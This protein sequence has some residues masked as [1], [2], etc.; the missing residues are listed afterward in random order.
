MLATLLLVPSALPAIQAPEVGIA[1]GRLAG[2]R[3]NGVA[4]FKGIPYAAPPVGPL[5]WRAPQSGPSWNGVRDAA[6]FGPVCPQHATEGLV[7][8]A[9]LPQSEDC[10][11]LNVWTPDLHPA[12]GLPVMVWIH[13]GGFDQGGSSVP[14]YDGGALA[15][16]GIVVV[17]FN[18]RLGRLGFFALPALAAEHPGEPFANYGLL[19]QIAALQWVR[20]NI[21]A[22]GGDPAEVTIF[23]ESAGGVSVDALMASPAARGL[24]ARAISESGAV[25]GTAELADAERSA[26][27][28]AQRLG[29]GGDDAL[30]KLRSASVDSILAAQ[31]DENGPVVDG[32]LLREDIA[33]A[34]AEGHIARVPYLT[35]TNS[36]EGSLLRGQT[37]DFL[38]AP[39]GDRLPSVRARYEE[40]GKI[41]DAEFDRLLFNDYFFAATS[42]LLAGFVAR[43]GGAAYVYRFQ[44][45]PAILRMRHAP[46]VMHGGEMAFVFGFG[47]LGAF[48][49]PQDLAVRDMVQAYWTNFAK[50]GDPNGAGLPEWPRFEG[51]APATLVIDDTTRAVPDFRKRETDVPL[52]M[53]AQRNRLPLP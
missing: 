37:A 25:F 52:E 9:D 29:A 31:G 23:G 17:T 1:A 42:R 43:A 24:F 12:A 33:V 32:T 4:V 45:L 8:R 48:A 26:A 20:D 2:A 38:T 3:A 44:F 51:A 14:R 41:S 27:A 46:G 39:L 35:G 40:G 22:F 50:T 11:T 6:S 21:A 19:D 36:D 28:F 10:L 47:P 53:W 18:Y 30:A 13:G 34:F 49:P 16:H 7:A 15:Q 5:R